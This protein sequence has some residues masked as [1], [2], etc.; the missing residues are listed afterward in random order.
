MLRRHVLTTAAAAATVYPFLRAATAQTT[1]AAGESAALVAQRQKILAGS[2]F[3][4]TSSQLAL[5]KG[6]AAAVQSFA[7]FEIAEQQSMLR[8]M[9]LAGLTLPQSV[10]LDSEKMTM[11]QQLQ[12][13]SGPEFDR[14]YVRGQL[15]G[16]RELLALHQSMV[17]SGTP[18]EQIIAT[19]AVTSIEQHIAM[20]QAL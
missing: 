20:L 14:L 3:A 9:Q 16:H 10:V 18:G 2:T 19:L 15:V 11:T 13:A 17:T 1:G 5:Q 6:S 12:A 7:R 4:T 8:A